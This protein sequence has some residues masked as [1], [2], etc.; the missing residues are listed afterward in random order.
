MKMKYMLMIGASAVVFTGANAAEPDNAK[1]TGATVVIPQGR[2]VVEAVPGTTVEVAPSASVQTTTVQAAPSAT[3]VDEPSGAPAWR[4]RFHYDRDANTE[5]YPD[6]EFTI[7]LF[8]AYAKE[9]RKFND[10]FDK[11]MRHGDWG[12]GVGVNYFFMKGFGIGADAYGLDNG[13]DFV[14]AVNG[15]LIFRLPIDVAHLAP[16]VFGG[17]GRQF[18][19]SDT[20]TLHAGAGLEIRLNSHTGIFL[21]GRH[22]FTDKGSDYALLRSGLRLAF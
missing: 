12:A 10:T 3:I 7:D 9:K 6:Q 19:G 16:Y 18:Q 2:T 17:G 5:L 11:T 21:D 14:D 1:A 22:V 4:D 20:W 13:S 8:G 15:S